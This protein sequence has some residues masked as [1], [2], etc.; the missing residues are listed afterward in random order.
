METLREKAEQQDR[1]VMARGLEGQ[2]LAVNSAWNFVVI[3]LGDRQGVVPHAEMI[4]MRDGQRVGK[5][6]ITSVEPST[7]IADVVPGSVS[8]GSSVRPGDR[9][10]YPGA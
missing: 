5:V 8:R 1:R 3:S 9:V 6:K 2:I 7:S 4:V 10:I